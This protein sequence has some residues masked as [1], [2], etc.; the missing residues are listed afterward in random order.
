MKKISCAHPQ[1][2]SLTV[3][4]LNSIGW[5]ARMS[6][7]LAHICSDSKFHK[8][9]AQCPAFSKLLICKEDKTAAF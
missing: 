3:Q 4:E 5:A 9:Q 1:F 8:M 2:C 6:F 7:T